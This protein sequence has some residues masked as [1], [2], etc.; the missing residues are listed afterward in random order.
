MTDTYS[1]TLPAYTAT[2]DFC[3]MVVSRATKNDHLVISINE[4]DRGSFRSADVPI[5][6]FIRAFR[7]LFNDLYT[8]EMVNEPD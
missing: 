8:V 6:V 1:T 3:D 2:G 4:Q 7:H 5:N